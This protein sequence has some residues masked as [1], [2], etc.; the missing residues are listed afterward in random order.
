MPVENHVP[1]DTKTAPSH[2]LQ[3]TTGGSGYLTLGGAC[4]ASISVTKW[5]LTRF[6]CCSVHIVA[7]GFVWFGAYHSLP[8][9]QPMDQAN[10]A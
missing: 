9:G 1:N 2:K 7:Q 3:P 6:R 8:K 5:N 4:Y 10:P